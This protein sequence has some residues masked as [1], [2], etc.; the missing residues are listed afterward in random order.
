MDVFSKL[1][2]QLSWFP[3]QRVSDTSLHYP[4]GAFWTQK[5]YTFFLHLETL[6]QIFAWGKYCSN[7]PHI[8]DN[9]MIYKNGGITR[10]IIQKILN[11]KPFLGVIENKK[12]IQNM[13][14]V[15]QKFSFLLEIYRPYSKY[16]T[17]TFFNL[18]FVAKKVKT[19]FETKK[20][21]LNNEAKG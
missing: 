11:L 5:V 6:I 2:N 10:N 9:R 7:D 4:Q 19:F 17:Y 14:A 15:D 18:H 20:F 12:F 1:G 8:I 16:L 3:F 13:G 21:L